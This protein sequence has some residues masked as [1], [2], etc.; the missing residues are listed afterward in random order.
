MSG[1][2]SGRSSSSPLPDSTVSWRQ[3]QREAEDRLAAAGLAMPGAD[4]RLLVETA[5]DTSG[6]D[7]LDVLDTPVTVRTL[8]R[9]DAMVH[10]RSQR[11]PL[12][13]VI[14][15]WP[16]RYLDLFVDRRVLIP[17]P[18]TEMVTEYALAE[19]DRLI[20]RRDTTYADRLPVVDLGTGSGAIALAIASERPLTDVWATDVSAEAL[21]VAR[22]NLAGIGRAGARVRL[23]EGTWYSAVPEE[24]R[25]R[26]AVVVTNPPYV[27]EEEVLAPEVD[28]W[29][30]VGALRSGPDGLSAITHIIG[31]AVEWLAPD[32]AL[33]VELAP[34]QASHVAGLARAAGFRDVAIRADL[35][36]RDRALVARR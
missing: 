24:L 2:G 29:E 22:A 14:G 21:A 12:Q 27:G 31:G 16:F 25:G 36:G 23:G 30:P 26:V 1:D 20:K 34:A 5:T 11:E 19:V 9:F 28:D 8:A 3:L 32:G 33:V 18:E 15:R 35:A 17:R 6:A 4:A 7:Y 13:Y 10:R